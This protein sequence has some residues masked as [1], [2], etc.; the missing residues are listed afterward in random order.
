MEPFYKGFEYLLNNFM[1]QNEQNANQAMVLNRILI[2]A[3]VISIF[4]Q[5]YII[6]VY[7][8]IEPL[9]LSHMENQ[10]FD[11]YQLLKFINSSLEIIDFSDVVLYEILGSHRTGTIKCQILIMKMVNHLIAF[12]GITDFLI[13]IFENKIKSFT[14]NVF[15][16][17]NSL[18]D[19]CLSYPSFLWKDI[20]LQSFCI[21][22]FLDC[23]N[24]GSISFTDI[25]LLILENSP[26]YLDII[27][28]SIGFNFIFSN[29]LSD[30]YYIKCF[31]FKVFCTLVEQK[32]EYI[33]TLRITEDYLFHIIELIPE[34][35]NY[36]KILNLINYVIEISISKKFVIGLTETLYEY[37]IS[38]I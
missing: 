32:M 13:Y 7:P 11:S 1:F 17:F 19:I 34:H 22:N 28:H 10:E 26:D 18:C 20:E 12:K 25:V 14:F 30:A 9:V 37:K 16:V 36:A 38:I 27:N 15:H 2:A 24:L 8:G 21:N 5:Q 6:N 29:Y 3:R 31:K 35:F 23:K 33:D 4:N